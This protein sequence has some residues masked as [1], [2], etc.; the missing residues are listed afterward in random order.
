MAENK[1]CSRDDCPSANVRID[2]STNCGKCGVLVHLLCLGIS[3]TTE[4]VLFHKNIKIHCNKCVSSSPSRYSSTTA[5]KTNTTTKTTPIINET[6]NKNNSNNSS[7]S[8]GL[9]KIDKI[10]SLLDKIDNSVET[11]KHTVNQ[12]HLV[13]KTNE[14]TLNEIKAST[15]EINEKMNKSNARPLF[16]SI[17]AKTPTNHFNYSERLFPPL[18]MKNPKRRRGDDQMRTPTETPKSTFKNRK[19][20]AGTSQIADHGLGS[21][22]QAKQP[23]RLRT[24]LTRSLYVS[25]LQT[26]VTI[27]RLLN[28]IKGKIPDLNENDISLRMLVKKDQPLDQLTFVSYRLMCTD[29]LYEEFANA[30]FWPAH[31]KIGEFIDKPRQPKIQVAT[32]ESPTP[33]T[34]NDKENNGESTTK[35]MEME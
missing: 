14:I 31:V 25:R 20:T 3:K 4:Q 15:I 7:S 27:D 28:Y 11:T 22:V 12:H 24:N 21:P 34:P 17:A 8:T 2:S 29:G 9:A 30:A 33:L 10:L 32:L 6:S 19:L 18:H 16:S 5:T 23:A 13:T 35:E 1:E 26:T